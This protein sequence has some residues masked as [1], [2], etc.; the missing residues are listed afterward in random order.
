MKVLVATAKT[1]GK[2]GNDFMH[3]T[4]GELVTFGTQCDRATPD[5]NCG[6]AR[7]MSGMES[8]KATTTIEVVDQPDMTPAKLRDAIR[9]G[10]VAGAFD[11]LYT[12]SADKAEFEKTIDETCE[13]LITSAEAFSEGAVLEFR[14]FEF[15]RRD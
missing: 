10:L 15:T 6:C 3:A 14:A 7:A 2:R 1:Q 11:K 9:A 12:T 5:D 4:P 8:L 13:E